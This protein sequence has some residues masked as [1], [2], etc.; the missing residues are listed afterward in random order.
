MDKHFTASEKKF[1]GNSLAG[2]AI[3]REAAEVAVRE[4]NRIATAIELSAALGQE[5]AEALKK[6]RAEFFRAYYERPR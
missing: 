1:A 6:L 2:R 4:L 5:D 3:Q